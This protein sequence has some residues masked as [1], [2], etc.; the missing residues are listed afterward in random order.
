MVIVSLTFPLSANTLDDFTKSAD[1]FLKNYVTDGSVAY[2][3]IKSNPS[4]IQQLYKTIGALSLAGADAKSKKAFYINAY[5]LIVIFSIVQNYPVKSPMDIGGFFDNKKHIVSG[6]SLTLNQLEKDKL[7][8]V[9]N[10]A[11][12]HF[13][14][15][16]A[17]KSCPQ[18]MKG[19]FTP[20]NIDEQLEQRTKKSLNDNSWL[21]VNDKQ[22]TT[23]V[24]KIFEWYKG[25][26]TSSGQS[27]LSWINKYRSEKIPS[28]Y[29]ISYYEYNW[30]L[31]E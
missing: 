16:C 18:L 6:E 31:N 17:A 4:E 9:Y 25:D 13:A 14:L 19:A 20:E 28:N 5:N 27:L 24:S 1:N 12:F 26:F 21:K 11:R 3:K 30:A 23:E 7:L 29:K 10:D 22:K 8:S 2:G 15:V